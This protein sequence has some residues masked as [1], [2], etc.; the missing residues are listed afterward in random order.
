MTN[1]EASAAGFECDRTARAILCESIARVF[2]YAAGRRLLG[3]LGERYGRRA[4]IHNRVQTIKL[5][6]R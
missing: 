4:R 2:R 5:L 6:L 1:D 3:D